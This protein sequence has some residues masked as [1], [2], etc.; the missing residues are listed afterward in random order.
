MYFKTSPFDLAWDWVKGVMRANGTPNG[1]ASD[2]RA[3]IFKCPDCEMPIDERI[4]KSNVRVEIVEGIPSYIL[5]CTWC[6]RVFNIGS[7]EEV[8]KT[9]VIAKNE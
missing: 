8:D 5:S 1:K 9:F 3:L 4:Q 6:Y 7:C 2:G